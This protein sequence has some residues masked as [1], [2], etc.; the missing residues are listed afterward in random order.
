MI[1]KKA[2]LGA[3]KRVNH[4]AVPS[5]HHECPFDDD[6]QL[7][8][9]FIEEGIGPTEDKLAINGTWLSRS[10]KTNKMIETFVVFEES[11]RPGSST[12]RG[13]DRISTGV[14]PL[15]SMRP[16]SSYRIK[17]ALSDTRPPSSRLN[18]SG[19]SRLNTGSSTGRISIEPISDIVNDSSGLTVG[20]AL[21]GNPLKALMAR[22]KPNEH[23]LIEQISNLSS[24]L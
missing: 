5:T 14:R 7:I 6:W 4:E 10:F 1:N 16:L 18:T 2:V 20:P 23:K 24:N 11:L 13:N 19:S 12:I 9:Q 15:S 22:R 21:Q 17:T 8:N 3:S